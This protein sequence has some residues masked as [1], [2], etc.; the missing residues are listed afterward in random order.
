[1]RINPVGTVEIRVSD[2]QVEA[3][4]SAQIAAAARMLATVILRNG[5]YGL[6]PNDYTLRCNLASVAGGSQ[7][8]R[9]HNKL[10]DLHQVASRSGMPEEAELIAALRGR[11]CQSLT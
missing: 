8:C 6:A 5:R 11:I 10:D 7:V 1:M 3:E 9:T 4:H 2:M